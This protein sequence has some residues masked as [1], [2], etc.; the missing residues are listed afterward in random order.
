MNPRSQIQAL[1]LCTVLTPGILAGVLV[2]RELGASLPL[3]LAVGAAVGLL[4]RQAL[5]AP[6]R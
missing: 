2:H 6:V 5:L 3:A 1:T 4:G